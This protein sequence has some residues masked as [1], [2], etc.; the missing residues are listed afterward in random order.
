LDAS[1]DLLNSVKQRFDGPA[2]AV[3][4]KSILEKFPSFIRAFRA[5][6]YVILLGL[7][8]GLGVNI[9]PAEA[10][11]RLTAIWDPSE[12]WGVMS[13]SSK[14][15][16]HYLKGSGGDT[17]K[18]DYNSTDSAT[19]G[20]QQKGYATLVWYMANK[21]PMRFAPAPSKWSQKATLEWIDSS[22]G[23]TLIE[24]L[25]VIGDSHHTKYPDIYDSIGSYFPDHTIR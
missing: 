12:G 7:A 2:A 15:G 3:A 4:S 24:K 18:I 8:A 10:S 13:N 14:H 6:E 1:A 16:M 19:L 11:K 21:R 23:R 17:R 5:P 22:V 25:K 9:S 20:T